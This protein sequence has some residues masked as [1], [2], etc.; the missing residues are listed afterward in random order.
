MAELD[1]VR[2]ALDCEL[3][4]AAAFLVVAGFQGVQRFVD[5][6][7]AEGDCFLHVSVVCDFII[8]QP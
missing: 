2:Q 1:P 8:I 5:L 3:V 7:L 4:K 6:A